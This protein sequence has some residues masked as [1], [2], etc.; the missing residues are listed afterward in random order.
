LLAIANQVTLFKFTLDCLLM[1]C[2]EFVRRSRSM[3]LIMCQ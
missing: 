1:S 3:L 2:L